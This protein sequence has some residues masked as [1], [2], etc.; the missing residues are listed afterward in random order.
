VEIASTGYGVRSR[1][2]AYLSAFCP[3]LLVDFR[4]CKVASVFSPGNDILNGNSVLEATGALLFNY[5]LKTEAHNIAGFGT[6]V[7]QVAELRTTLRMD[8]TG[9][10]VVTDVWRHGFLFYKGDYATIA[11]QREETYLTVPYGSI[12]AAIVGGADGIL[13]IALHEPGLAARVEAGD[14]FYV[15]DAALLTIAY[16]PEGR[17]D[18]PVLPA[19][20]GFGS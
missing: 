2:T 5:R 14:G 9:A 7:P 12:L 20:A 15:S 13:Q 19:F 17:S 3:T 1:A 4:D 18:F 6:Y 10:A 16:N 8:T 11:V